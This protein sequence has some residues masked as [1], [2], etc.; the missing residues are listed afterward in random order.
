MNLNVRGNRHNHTVPPDAGHTPLEDRF[1]LSDEVNELRMS[2]VICRS[3]IFRFPSVICFRRCQFS[4]VR[5][6]S[7]S[8]R[9]VSATLNC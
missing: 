6:I 3:R 2:E 5:T 7:L 9:R 1:Q 4:L 8:S